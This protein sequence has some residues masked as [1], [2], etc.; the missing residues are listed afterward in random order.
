MTS[1]AWETCLDLWVKV[2]VAVVI[3]M[4]LDPAS[5]LDRVSAVAEPRKTKYHFEF[6]ARAPRI[7][8]LFV[9]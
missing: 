6:I 7:F 2:P 9:T 8:L 3:R 1:I 4:V 5:R